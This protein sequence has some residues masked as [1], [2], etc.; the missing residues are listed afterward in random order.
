MDASHLNSLARR[1]HDWLSAQQHAV[2][3]GHTLDFIAAIPGLRN[4]PEVLAH[5]DRVATAQVNAVTCERLAGR[6]EK[7][8]GVRLPAGDL[9]AVLTAETAKPLAVWPTGPAAGLWL[10]TSQDAVNAVIRQYEIATGNGPLYTE[11]AGAGAPTAIDLGEHGLYSKGLGRLPPGTLLVIG[12]LHFTQEEWEASGGRLGV[13]ANLVYEADL[14]VVALCETP[15]PDN[16]DADVTLLLGDLGWSPDEV[17]EV[18]RGRV[19][20]DGKFVPKPARPA[21]PVPPVSVAFAPK[22]P[23]PEPLAQV[24]RAGLAVR[25]FGLVIAASWNWKQ[26]RVGLLEATLPFTDYAGPAARIMPDSRTD[27]DGDPPL[28]DAFEGLPVF[29]S[30]ESAYASGYRRMIFEKTRP[31]AEFLRKHLDDVC[32]HLSSFG[33]SVSQALW[34]GMDMRM[35]DDSGV[36]GHVIAVL[37]GSTLKAR[38]GSWSFTDALAAPVGL[39][40]DADTK[41]ID[42]YVRTQRMLR[43]EDQLAAGIESGSVTL[44]E[45]K[46]EFHSLAF[47]DFAKRRKAALKPVV[48]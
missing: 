10:A 42:Q 4:W 20:S 1:L 6:I 11:G 13:T 35:M 17:A 8:L 23:L 19:A 45:V 34:H 24:L 29:P 37:C 39:T 14:R 15:Q 21:V 5:P 46:K 9:L 28:L 7:K 30:A 43:W 3:H 48:H 38:R 16:L 32:F 47:D 2:K 25:R 31:G 26:E 27:W 22:E 36:V 40:L 12:P 41:A 44:A 18:V 33:A